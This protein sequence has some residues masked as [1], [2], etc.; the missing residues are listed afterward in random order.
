MQVT[1]AQ[2]HREIQTLKHELALLDARCLSTQLYFTRW[3]YQLMASKRLS[4]LETNVFWIKVLLGVLLCL[5]MIF[6][7]C[8]L[9]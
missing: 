8:F 1:P 6:L 3:R 7:R 5:L 2:M 4:D 9:I